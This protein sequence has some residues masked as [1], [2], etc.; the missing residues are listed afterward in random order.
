MTTRENDPLDVTD[1]GNVDIFS[2]ERHIAAQDC[3]ITVWS[4]QAARDRDGRVK[5]QALHARR[6]GVPIAVVALDATPL[7]PWLEGAPVLDPPIEAAAERIRR[8][9]NLA[10]VLGP[11][12][13]S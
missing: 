3:F 13:G 8:E 5:R 2:E 4:K 6:H 11:W 12:E 7:P 9:P 1:S 10:R